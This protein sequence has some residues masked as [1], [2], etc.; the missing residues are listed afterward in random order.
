MYAQGADAKVCDKEGIPA[1][2]HAVMNKHRDIIP[3]LISEGADVHK[4]G[5]KWVPYNIIERN[6]AINLYLKWDLNRSPS[7]IEPS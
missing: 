3:L 5:P 6:L 1:L 4:K 2:Q 7:S